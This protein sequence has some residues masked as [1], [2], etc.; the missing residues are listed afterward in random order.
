MTYSL[1][2]YHC[3]RCNGLVQRT[4]KI[5][6]H[7]NARLVGIRCN[8]CGF[9]GDE[10]N[11]T[12]GCP[13]CGSYSIS[14][15]GSVDYGS[16]WAAGATADSDV[17]PSPV[18]IIGCLGTLLG[19]IFSGWL[20][21]TLL[22]FEIAFVNWLTIIFLIFLGILTIGQIIGLLIEISSIKKRGWKW[23]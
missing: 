4:T 8:N 11:F 2:E 13:Q 15:F 3:S 7:C 10:Y 6:P 18:S 23:M 1:T 21:V 9:V 12:N 16:V 20:A 17:P 5:C 19:A 14:S 22:L